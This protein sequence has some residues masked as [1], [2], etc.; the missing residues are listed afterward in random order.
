VLL[1]RVPTT[2]ETLALAVEKASA[3]IELYTAEADKEFAQQVLE[4]AT[5]REEMLL[6]GEVLIGKDIEA[7]NAVVLLGQAWELILNADTELRAVTELSRS[8]GYYELR[9]AIDR[10]NNVLAQLDQATTLLAQAK[11]AFSAVNFS[12]LDNYLVLRIESVRIAIEADQALLDANLETSTAL[13]EE[14]RK[15]DEVVVAAAAL[16]AAQP[17]SLITD[18][19]ELETAEARERYN[20]AR[21]N[22]AD[23]DAYIRE[24]VGV[25]MQ[26]GVQ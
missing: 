24:Y 5:N 1:E 2:L 15:K 3:S 19:Y 21:G 22:A 25:E 17:L 4:A 11:E 9:E 20:S 6:S 7:M 13:N 14:F 12:S 16:I 18:A 8:G 26:T 23:A 10:S